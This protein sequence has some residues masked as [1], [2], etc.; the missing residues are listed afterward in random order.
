[1]KCGR[2]KKVIE[3]NETNQY[4]DQILE[5]RHQ[6][7]EEE[8]DLCLKLLEADGT[9]YS[10]AFAH[11]YLADAYHSMG[12]LTRAMEQYH[13]AMDLIGKNNFEKLSLTLYNL[14]GVIY[15]GL[16]DEQGALDCFFKEV[17]IAE[18]ME[19]YM[20]C[21]A[22]L[23]NIAYVYRSAGAF[24]KAER[25][26]L[27]AHEMAVSADENDTNIEFT[28]DVYNM[29]QAG[30]SIEEG[31]P[32]KALKYLD[33]VGNLR[34]QSLDVILMYASCYAKNG[35]KEAALH[36]V[37]SSLDAVENIR[38]RFERLSHYFDILD[39]LMELEEYEEAEKF[40]L[41]AEALLSKMESIGK[42]SRLM[43]YEIRIYNALG[44]KQKLDR[45]YELFFE[46]NM[47]FKEASRKAA[48]KRLRKRI[49]LHEESN[50]RADMEKWQNVLHKRSE[51]DELT[52]VLNR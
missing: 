26:L 5:V 18:Q 38:N 3:M 46:Y 6:S 10:R 23:A 2:N 37:N 7:P 44:D 34:G 35:K 31:K 27:R 4:M 12:L 43:D 33:S 50:K 22:A 32:D 9:E 1:M 48:V 28:E 51:Y 40:V 11:T 42:W 16:D 41:K 30:L 39:I 36:G 14:A 24:K 17:E 8:R 25:T 45:A 20:M 13:T 29:L 19:D 52:G 49:E 15:I 47:K 21:S